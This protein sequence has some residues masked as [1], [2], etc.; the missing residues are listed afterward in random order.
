MGKLPPLLLCSQYLEPWDTALHDFSSCPGPS[1][2]AHRPEAKPRCGK[3]KALR[4]CL[5]VTAEARSEWPVHVLSRLL[6]ILNA[7]SALDPVILTA[8]SHVSF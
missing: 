7:P 1:S 6:N 4:P 3:Q 5:R 2:L 8:Q